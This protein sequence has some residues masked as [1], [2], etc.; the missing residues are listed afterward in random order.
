MD[1]VN[2]QDFLGLINDL[3]KWKRSKAGGAVS[4]PKVEAQWHGSPLARP[5]RRL[6]V[7]STSRVERRNPSGAT[8]SGDPCIEV[9]QDWRHQHRCAMMDQLGKVVRPNA[10]RGGASTVRQR[11]VVDAAVFDSE[12]DHAEFTGGR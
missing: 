5:S 12:G 9:W 11:R 1:F 10:H 7:A 6:K 2:L 8:A 3:Q 4:G